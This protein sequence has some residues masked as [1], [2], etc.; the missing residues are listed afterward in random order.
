MIFTKRNLDLSDFQLKVNDYNFERVT[1][2]K[3]LGVLIN[4]K[5]TWHDHI[6]VVCNKIAKSIG[7]LRKVHFYPQNILKMLYH[8]LITPYFNYCIITWAN[9]FKLIPILYFINLIF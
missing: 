9:I 4:H 7:I 6:G 3:F 2:L 8:T 1:T 5:L